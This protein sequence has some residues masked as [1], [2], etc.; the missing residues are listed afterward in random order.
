MLHQVKTAIGHHTSGY[1]RS[2]GRAQQRRMKKMTHRW[3]RAVPGA[4]AGRL[5]RLGGHVT[6]LDSSREML[7]IADRV[8]SVAGTS[9]KIALKQG[10]AAQL[11]HLFPEGSFDLVLC[12]NKLEFVEDPHVVLHGIAKLMRDSSTVLSV[13][14]RNRARRDIKGCHP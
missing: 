8:A 14:V 1:N 7:H 10:D 5:T 9:E 4:T 12:H 2:L 6:P 13:L 3:P 11:A